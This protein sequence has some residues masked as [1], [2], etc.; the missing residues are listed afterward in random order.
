MALEEAIDY[1]L[2]GGDEPTPPAS[3]AQEEQA[4][5]KQPSAL[6]R[7]EQEVANLIG[8]RF[9]SRQI[10]SE[11]HLSE[12]T[13]NKHVTNILRKLNL[14]SREQVGTKMAEQRS[15]LF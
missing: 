15:H 4:S 11:L 6:T 3:S 2:L 14:H 13:V 12:H 1:A 8:R 10:A 9:T 7:R 5:A